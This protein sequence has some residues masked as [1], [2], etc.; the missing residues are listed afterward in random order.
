MRLAQI[1]PPWIPV[2]PRD[3]GGTELM[4]A[5]LIRGL[6]AQGVEVILFASRD[7]ALLPALGP[8]PRSLWPPEKFSENLHLSYAFA[9]MGADPPQVIHSHL[10]IAAGFWAVNRGPAPLAITLHT[11]LSPVKIDYLRSFPHVWAVAVSAFQLGQLDGRP[12]LALIPHGLP[13][14]D[15]PYEEKKEDYLLFLGRIYPDKGAHTAIRLA[16]EAGVRLV[17]AGPVYPPD[18]SY[19]IAEIMPHLDGD[20][21]NYVGPADFSAK[22]ALLSRARGLVS[23]VEVDEAFGLALVEAMA[24]GTPVLTYGRGAAPEVV[25]HGA[26]GF[27]VHTY[28]EMKEA[29]MRLPDLDPRQ[30]RS[31]VELHFCQERMVSAYLALYTEMLEGT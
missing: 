12:R 31:H 27:V 29:L 19:F 18:Q 14:D 21:V 26:T 15:Y 25:A 24:C 11:P 22:I 20:A 10:E 6:M 5:T 17:I 8:F 30:C 2:P 3:Y 7:S 13:L 1:S 23:P 9:R 16:R 4:V 28:N